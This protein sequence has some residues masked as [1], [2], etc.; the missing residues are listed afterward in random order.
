[1]TQIG[2]GN[3]RFLFFFCI[4][5]IFTIIQKESCRSSSF[6]VE[7]QTHLFLP[8]LDRWIHRVI[9]QQKINNTLKKKLAHFATKSSEI[10][11]SSRK[12]D[13]TL[14]KRSLLYKTQ[15]N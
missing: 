4:N 15:K 14:Q 8:K 13:S 5:M 11:I 7:T 9:F 2:E 3:P 10:I 1:V 6:G 12:A